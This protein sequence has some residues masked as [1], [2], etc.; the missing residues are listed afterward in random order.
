MVATVPEVV[1][2]IAATFKQRKRHLYIRKRQAPSEPITLIGYK[3]LL[4]YKKAITV[5]D[6]V[7]FK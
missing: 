4:N 6:K 5:L 1:I 2:V 7:L 3:L